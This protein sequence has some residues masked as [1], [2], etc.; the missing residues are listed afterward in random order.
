MELAYWI[1]GNDGQRYGPANLAQLQAWVDEGRVLADTQ[2]NR[3]DAQDWK[4]A[5]AFE[6]LIWNRPP[7]PPGAARP[8]LAAS[9]AVVGA[10]THV[11]AMKSGADW[12]LWIA[13]LSVV[14]V[15]SIM[16]GSGFGFIIALAVTNEINR[17]C[18]KLS[19]SSGAI[20][21]AAFGI[22]VVLNLLA[23]G[24]F[25]MFGLFARKGH[26]WAFIAGIVFYVVDALLCVLGGQ[27]LML[28]FHAWALFSIVLGMRSALAIRRQNA[29]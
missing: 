1:T 18:F 11:R 3:T 21:T 20:G 28:A 16:S 22:S 9:A 19:E 6:E 24:L 2:V 4:A 27:W 8:P 10:E 15:V 23:I 29:A 5:S 17:F 12:F 14:N 25:V 13:G 26:I 7:Q